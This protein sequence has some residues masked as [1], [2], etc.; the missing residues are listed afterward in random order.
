MSNVNSSYWSILYSLTEREDWYDKIFDN[1]IIE[2]WRQDIHN[3]FDDNSNK[4]DNGYG[5]NY[6]IDEGYDID[7]VFDLCIKFLRATAQGVKHDPECK[8]DEQ[9]FNYCDECIKDIIQDFKESHDDD[10]KIQKMTNDEIRNID[11][12]EEYACDCDIENYKCKH[13]KCGCSHP[14]Y[15]LHNYIISIELDIESKYKNKILKF[16]DDLTSHKHIVKDELCI[17]NKKVVWSYHPDTNN[18]VIDIIHPSIF[19]HDNESK[20]ERCRYTWLPSDFSVD[21]NYKVTFDSYINNLH[22]KSMVPIISYYLSK[23]IKPFES[24]LRKRLCGKK[25]QVITKIAEINL[26][27]NN[28]YYPDGSWHIE[29]TEMEQ[30][31][32]TGLTYLRMENISK[33]YLEFRKPV[34]INDESMLEYPQNDWEHTNFH[35]GVEGH[36]DGKMNRYLGLIKCKENLSIVFP[37]SIQHRVKKFKLDENCD[38]GKRT[39]LVF[40]LI[41]PSKSI[42]ST[43]DIKEQYNKYSL[44]E[45]IYMRNRLMFHRK[46]FVDEING[47]VFE[48]EF[49]LCEH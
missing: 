12:F 27:Q 31:V 43:K 14:H 24:I 40:F 2:N 28:Y 30:I 35:Y 26:D 16:V 8:W 39:I 42:I 29:G 33:S 18:Q 21:N 7:L 15:S 19:C 4:Y 48:R 45:V 23:F 32:C 37:N 6:K 3:I 46:H 36:H 5:V 1:N 41:D 47:Q 38:S 13:Y 17:K 20:N 22:D 10:N 49:S 11:Y 9:D 34:I 44:D 25:L